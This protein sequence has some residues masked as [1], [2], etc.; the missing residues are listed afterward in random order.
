MLQGYEVCNIYVGPNLGLMQ[1]SNNSIIAKINH[2]L[3]S[4]KLN[5]KNNIISLS[6][7]ADGRAGLIQSPGTRP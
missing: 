3:Q 2:Y 5:K 1:L 4:T 7:W 6:K